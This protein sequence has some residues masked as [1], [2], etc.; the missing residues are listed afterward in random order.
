MP[1]IPDPV[2]ERLEELISAL[3]EPDNPFASE[4]KVMYWFHMYA[5]E[6]VSELGGE[7]V[8]YTFRQ[9]AD[10]CLM[11]YKARFDGKQKVVFTTAQNAS[12]CMRSF[13]RRLFANTLEWKDDKYA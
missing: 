4:L 7:E 5:W 12:L 3:H 9:K 2:R 13:C 6:Q 10:Q 1:S 8:G 11:V